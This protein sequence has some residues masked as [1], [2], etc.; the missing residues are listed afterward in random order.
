[1][2]YVD[3]P[4]FLV[5]DTKIYYILDRA[6]TEGFTEGG[7]QLSRSSAGLK[8]GN[9]ASTAL[10]DWPSEE[11]LPLPR[12][13]CYTQEARARVSLL[14]SAGGPDATYSAILLL[15]PGHSVLKECPVL[16]LVGRT[17]FV[18][19]P[20]LKGGEAGHVILPSLI[21]SFVSFLNSTW[22]GGLYSVGNYYTV[23]RMG[24]KF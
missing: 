22:E 21:C 6:S 15:S 17:E 18:S 19:F 12:P 1:M 23:V 24:Q 8:K 16:C 5:T 7:R 4:G 20:V 14:L 9:G 10:W 3:R 11:R 2:C 13:E